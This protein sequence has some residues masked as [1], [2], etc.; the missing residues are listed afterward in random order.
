MPNSSF[1]LT[2][3]TRFSAFGCSSQA[4]VK[5]VNSRTAR[6]MKSA[7]SGPNRSGRALCRPVR[8]LAFAAPPH[9]S[10][11]EPNAPLWRGFRIALVRHELAADG[12]FG[13][14]EIAVEHRIRDG[15]EMGHDVFADQAAGIGE[16]VRMLVG[17]RIEQQPRVLRRPCRADD[18][19]GRLDVPVAVAIEYSRPVAF[20]PDASVSTRVTVLSARTS[21]PAARASPR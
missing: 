1:W 3:S 8:P 4:A 16:P 19:A 21:A 7:R 14:F 10:K 6:F 2:S 5:R 18:D 11:V 12:A 15:R 9:T 17:R 13:A 20:L